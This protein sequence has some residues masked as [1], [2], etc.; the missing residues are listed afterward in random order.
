MTIDYNNLFE[1]IKDSLK[2]ERKQAASQ[3]YSKIIKFRKPREGSMNEYMFRILPYVKEGNEGLKKTFFYY[4]KYFWKDD[5]DP[6]SPW[7][8]VLSNKTFGNYCPISDYTYKVRQQGSEWE[9]E[10]VRSRLNHVVGRYCNVYVINDSTNP[11]NNGKVMVVS[12]NTTLWKKVRAALDGELDDEW[13]SRMTDANPD[14]GEIRVN[15]GRMV[16]DLTD[17]GINF[18]VRVAERGGYPEYN[19]SDFTRRDAKLHLTPEQQQQILDSCIDLSEL[20]RKQS[21]EEI[22]GLFTRTFLHKAAPAQQAQPRVSVQTPVVERAAQVAHNP[23]S[24]PIDDVLGDDKIPGLDSPKPES[25]QV[26]SVE[27]EMDD[28]INSLAKGGNPVSDEEQSSFNFA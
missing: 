7:Y 23:V 21:N 3:S 16:T 24:S 8:S 5:Q 26:S 11:E 1:G 27:S 2:N 17:N 6:D 19:S 12:L 4:E 25:Q 10:M 28:F 18:N 22:R 14:G 13:S 9:K 20:E 15:V